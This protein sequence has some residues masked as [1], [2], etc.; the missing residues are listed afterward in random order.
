[1]LAQN[2]THKFSMIA[3][4]LRVSTAENRELRTEN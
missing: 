1:V 2:R 3:A 4:A